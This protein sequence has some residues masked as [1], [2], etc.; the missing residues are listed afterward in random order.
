MSTVDI[1]LKCENPNWGNS[2]IFSSKLNININNIYHVAYEIF[3]HLWL[4]TKFLHIIC[5]LY[6]NFEKQTKQKLLSVFYWLGYWISKTERS[7]LEQSLRQGLGVCD[8]LRKCSTG[9]SWQGERVK[10]EREGE[11]R[12]LMEIP[13][14]AWIM[15]QGPETLT[16]PQ[17][18]FLLRPRCWSSM[19]LSTSHWLWPSPTNFLSEVAP[20]LA[21]G[22]FLRSRGICGPSGANTQSSCSRVTSSVNGI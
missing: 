14:L 15:G 7:C 12:G 1:N 2:A 6:Q 10:P 11:G 17:N 20:L 5:Q 4:L 9:K 22:N 16:I 21:Q 19:L 13:F 18:W 8:L 3:L